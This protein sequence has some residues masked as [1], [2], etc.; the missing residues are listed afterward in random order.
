[1][2]TVAPLCSIEAGGYGWLLRGAPE[3]QRSPSSPL[4][5][6][7]RHLQET[8]ALC[9][10][11]NSTYKN[12]AAGASVKLVIAVT[13]VMGFWAPRLDDHVPHEQ[14]GEEPG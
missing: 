14:G 3:V 8:S 13:A 1:M 4:S 7:T 12:L 10:A 2:A 9:R 11:R 5:P 6:D